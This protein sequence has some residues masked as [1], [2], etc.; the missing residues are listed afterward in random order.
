VAV[1]VDRCFWHGCPEHGTMPKANRPFWEEKLEANRLRNRDTDEQLE[2][3]GWKV[4]RYWEHA[5]AE[6]AAAEI[7]AEV[8]RRTSL[9]TSE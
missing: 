7:A 1:F 3:A 5:E 4:M 6:A 9:R 2:R 8:S